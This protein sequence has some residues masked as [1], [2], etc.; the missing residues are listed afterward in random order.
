MLRKYV[1]WLLGLLV[2]LAMVIFV[3]PPTPTPDNLTPIT[4][5]PTEVTVFFTKSKGNASVTEG[6]VRKLPPTDSESPVKPL[7]VQFAVQELLKGPSENEVKLGFFSEIPKGTRLLSVTESKTGLEINL[8]KEFVSGG[9]SNSMV[10]RMAE[11]RNTVVSSS[12]QKEQIHIQ[13]EGQPL[14]TAGGE[15]LEIPTIEPKTVQ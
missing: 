8:S 10:Q 7:P 15:G 14:E 11:L 5:Q 12:G 1:P 4:E 3:F 2:V 13:I 6:V 9:G